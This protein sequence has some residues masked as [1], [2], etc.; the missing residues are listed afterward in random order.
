MRGGVGAW[1]SRG[2]RRRSPVVRA[3]TPRGKNPWTPKVE[4]PPPASILRRA[5]ADRWR[6][7]WTRGLQTRLDE[8]ASVACRRDG[9]DSPT[10]H[11][12][13]EKLRA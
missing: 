9:S 3:G 12:A 7:C 11:G 6:Q 1:Q 4:Q 2:P 5:L 10:S 8:K 13:A